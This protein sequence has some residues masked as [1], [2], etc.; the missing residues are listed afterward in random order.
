MDL[1][2]IE[3]PVQ[4]DSLESQIQEFGQTPKLLFSNPHPPRDANEGSIEV[5]TPDLLLSPRVLLPPLIR[6]VSYPLDRVSGASELLSHRRREVTLSAFE[7]YE[8]S[9]DEVTDDALTRRRHRH[10]YSLVCFQTPWKRLP[11]AIEEIS[12]QMRGSICS[13]KLAK[14]WRWDTRLRTKY[15]LSTSWTWKQISTCQLHKSEVTSTVLSRDDCLLFTTGKDNYLRISRTED[16]SQ[17]RDTSG[18]SALSC[19]D[20][21]PDG[22][23]IFV[24]CWD[25]RVCMYSVTTG[26]VLDKLF[27]HSDGI[28]AIRVLQDRFLTS[29]WDSTI[30]LWRYTSKFVVAT[31]LRTFLECEESVMC[32][33]V[34]QDGHYGAAGSRNGSVYLF[35]LKA[36]TFSKKIHVGSSRGEGITSIA[37]AND[38]RSF[39]CVTVQ[40]ELFHFNV[41][42]DKLW[43]I[44]IRTAGQVR[45]FD[46]DGEYAIGGTTAGKLL[47][48]KL[49][50]EAGQELVHEIPQAHDACISALTVS[51]S[52]STL[53]SGAVDGSVHVWRL[54]EHSFLHQKRVSL[55]S[56]HTFP[57]YGSIQ[58]TSTSSSTSV[59]VSPRR[60]HDA[61]V[62]LPNPTAQV[63]E[64][65]GCIGF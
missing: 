25:N 5:A 2:A 4:K 54:Q 61:K 52:G 41:R 17:L 1:D 48:W 22:A 38:N 21:S 27:A 33:D 12:T 30:K 8:D 47:F 65:E 19:C 7:D 10:R 42:G 26:R 23:L 13:G 45:C 55:S 3:D 64:A 28:S 63:A 32:L 58:T 49:H 50:E 40:N 60:H 11:I 44:E 53:V 62:Y 15:S 59:S 16:T 37:F 39:V 51:C 31:P 56:R 46:S 57:N 43:A 35:D 36:I 29:S 14:K 18:Q 24:G 6:R 9:E 20:V 34:T